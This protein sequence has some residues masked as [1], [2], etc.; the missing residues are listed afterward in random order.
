MLAAA[1]VTFLLPP[2]DGWSDGYRFDLH[3]NTSSS[4]VIRKLRKCFS[5][6]GLREE[7]VS[8]NGPP[9]NEEEYRKF[10]LSK[11]IKC[12]FNTPPL[13]SKPNGAAEKCVNTVCVG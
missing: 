4:E 13:H 1:N 2:V 3:R 11:Y 12:T 10:S 8:D 9:F 5:V 6:F 7:L